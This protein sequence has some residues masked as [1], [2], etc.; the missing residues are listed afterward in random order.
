MHR[1]RTQIYL[2]P[3]QH[4]ALKAEAQMLR[5]S[6]AELM[7]RIVDE[8]LNTRNQ[9]PVSTK[10]D[11]FSLAG[12]RES[13]IHDVAE[14]HAHHLRV[15]PGITDSLE[16]SERAEPMP[17]AEFKLLQF[18]HPLHSGHYRLK[19]PLSVVIEKEKNLIVCFSPG[20]HIY[21]CGD[22]IDD[23]LQEFEH[24]LV[25]DYESY[26]NTPKEELT[27]DA[28]ILLLELNELLESVI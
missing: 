18:T 8:H 19:H 14:Q 16:S 26:S 15:M 27:Q 9:P 3:T 25:T 1:K 22:T 12:F 7:R 11:Y 13:G 10:E 2:K 24:I 6:L 17:Y 5:I 28:Q 4:K 21:G 20:Q 23:A